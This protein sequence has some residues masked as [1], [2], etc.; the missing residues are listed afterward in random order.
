[1]RNL[2]IIILVVLWVILILVNP[3]FPE[4][5]NALMGVEFVVASIILFL[6]Y[7]NFRED[8][9]ID[10]EAKAIAEKVVGAAN[11]KELYNK[12]TLWWM[13]L[14]SE[15]RQELILKYG[16]I[17]TQN[18]TLVYKVEYKDNDQSRS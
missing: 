14:S 18:I 16:T 13:S 3:H 17:N 8:Q 2:L 7:L 1:M 15:K 4:H 10:E 9:K 11:D 6:V 5:F 12:A